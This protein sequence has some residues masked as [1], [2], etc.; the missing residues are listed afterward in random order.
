M[1][2]LYY[3][4]QGE[5]LRGCTK[6]IAKDQNSNYIDVEKVIRICDYTIDTETKQLIYNPKPQSKSRSTVWLGP[7]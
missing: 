7:Q 3:N 1:Y 2:R 4:E 5:I 6:Q